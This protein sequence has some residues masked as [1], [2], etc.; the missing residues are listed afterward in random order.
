MIRR[1]LLT[2]VLTLATVAQAA[3]P[4]L[5]EIDRYRGL[6]HFLQVSETPQSM[7]PLFDAAES[8]QSAVMRIDDSGYAWLERVSD[9][10][11]VAI[12]AQLEGLRLHRG[13]DVYAE[14]DTA[15]MHDLALQHGRPVDQ[16]F[17]AGLKDAYNDQGLP[18]YLDLTNRASPCVRFD[19]PEVLIDQ[20]AHWQTFAQ[21][22]P[23]AYGK[24][25]GQWL[26]DI[27]DVM[28]QGTCTCTQEQ[29]PVEAALHAFV[30]A[31]PKTLVRADIQAR[32]QQL[33]NQPYEKPVWCR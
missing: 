32:L 31:F 6:L 23:G 28:A 12:Q 16:A 8:V 29:A 19:P 33:K 7:Q 14:L 5:P 1:T 15:V 20:Y 9:D 18:V 27:E 3:P 10:D 24:F 4:S 30:A 21:A 26:S 13:L 25:V 2:L 11:A 22:H 17:F